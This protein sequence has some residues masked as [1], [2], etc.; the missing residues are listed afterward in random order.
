[1]RNENRIAAHAGRKRFHYCDLPRAARASWIFISLCR[2][3]MRYCCIPIECYS[4]FI[5]NACNESAWQGAARKHGTNV[6]TGIRVFRAFRA[7]WFLRQRATAL[8]LI[9]FVPLLSL[10]FRGCAS[11][12]VDERKTRRCPARFT[13]EEDVITSVNYFVVGD[14]REKNTNPLGGSTS[15]KNSPL[16][17][18]IRGSEMRSSRN[19]M[20]ILNAFATVI[21]LRHWL[22]PTSVC[23]ATS[24]LSVIVRCVNQPFPREVAGNSL[25]K[26]RRDANGQTPKIYPAKSCKI[27]STC[28]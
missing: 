10:R 6:G 24:A 4:L 18:R 27:L 5:R 7:A 2:A 22:M 25:V 23:T 28:K 15:M 17:S 16:V 14:T 12:S 21:L 1:M 9:H 19:G 8:T 3:T 13:G 20:R 11:L 26:S